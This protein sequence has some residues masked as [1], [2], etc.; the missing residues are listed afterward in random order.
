MPGT[1]DFNIC[2][3]CSQAIERSMLGSPDEIQQIQE[4]NPP[5][6]DHPDGNGPITPLG[7][8]LVRKLFHIEYVNDML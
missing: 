2:L 7:D 6:R 3:Q 1:V 8:Q 5:I 4:E